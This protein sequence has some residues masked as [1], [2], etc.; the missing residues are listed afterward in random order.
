MTVFCIATGFVIHHHQ[1]ECI[2]PVPI[3]VQEDMVTNMTM[4]VMK[5]AM[6]AGMRIEMVMVMGGKEN[7]AIG[8]TTGMENKGIHIVVTEIVM[9]ENM[10][11]AT[12]EKVLGMMITEEEVEV[13]MITMTLE[14][15]ALIERESAHWMMMANIHLGNCLLLLI[16]LNH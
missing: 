13:L 11:N 2:G 4:I 3:R 16:I 14:V 1:A 10:M 7:R 8:M 12:A 5:A 15:E 9:A 6:E